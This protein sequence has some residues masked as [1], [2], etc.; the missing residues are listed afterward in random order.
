MNNLISESLIALKQNKIPNPE[1]DLRILLKY[2]SHSNKEIILS[3]FDINNIDL[4]LF[5][6][7][8]IKRL[9]NEPISKIINKKSFWKC[10][11]YVDSNVLDPRPETELIIEEVLKNTKN[12]KSKLNILDIG[13]GSG[14]LAISLAQELVNSKILAIDIS[15]KALIVADKN[16]KKYNLQNRVNIKCSEFYNLKE[17]FDIIVSNPPYLGK[18]DFKNLQLEIKQYEPEIALYGGD[19]GL[20]FYRLFSKSIHK[21]LNKNAIFICEIGNNDISD[22]KEIFKDSDLI[23]KNVSKDIQ[24]IDR[25]LTFLKI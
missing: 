10:D 22:Y 9:N 15:S 6:N 24:N 3:N 20:D 21:Y 7:L 11:F 23:L 17:K 5:K 2:A 25:T 19:D 4:A 18:K 12:N 8:I 16:I 13:T 14:C 1:L